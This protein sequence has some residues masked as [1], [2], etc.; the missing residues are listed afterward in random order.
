MPDDKRK[1]IGFVVLYGILLFAVAGVL[2]AISLYIHS[3]SESHTNEIRSTQQTT[4]KNV[5][6]ENATL[7]QLVDDL[8]LNAAEKAKEIERL[9]DEIAMQG[10]HAEM[11]SAMSIAYMHCLNNRFSL[12]R[13]MFETI[14]PEHFT[15]DELASYERLKLRIY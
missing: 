2:I 11:L 7:R 13:D 1:S 12:A 9:V 8:N 14:N 5:Q 6:D 3:R 4:L 10:K 15:E